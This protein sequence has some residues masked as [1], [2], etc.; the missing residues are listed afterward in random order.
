MLAEHP[1]WRPPPT[2]AISPG[3][4]GPSECM[5]ESPVHR[6]GSGTR[7]WSGRGGARGGVWRTPVRR[8]TIRAGLHL[9]GSVDSGTS[10]RFPPDNAPGDGIGGRRKAPP[11]RR[12]VTAGGQTG[13]RRRCAVRP[14]SVPLGAGGVATLSG[15]PCPWSQPACWHQGAAHWRLVCR[16]PWDRAR[17]PLDGARGEESACL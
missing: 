5:A 13:I 10:A 1:S 14:R 16:C 12:A 7:E 4:D 11:T 2:S 15:R 9:P 6:S 8:R 17:P 3:S